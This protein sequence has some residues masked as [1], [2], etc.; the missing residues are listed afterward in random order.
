[1]CDVVC[2][3]Y[4]DVLLYFVLASFLPSSFPPFIPFS[5]FFY[6]K[7]SDALLEV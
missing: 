1:M 2:H 7:H 5:L 4:L 3:D 6:I